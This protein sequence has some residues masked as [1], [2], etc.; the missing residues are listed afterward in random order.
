LGKKCGTSTSVAH[1]STK[2]TPSGKA[3]LYVILE[4]SYELW[5]SVEGSR[6]GTG[7][8]TKDGTNKKY[9]GW[10]VEGIKKYNDY[11]DKVKLNQEAVGAKDVE[12]GV[13][14]TLKQ[15]YGFETRRNAIAV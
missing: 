13:V 7:N 1:V 11:M 10:T 15:W 9:C 12:E 6:V 8:L 5:I 14:N 3:Y 2:Y 4:N